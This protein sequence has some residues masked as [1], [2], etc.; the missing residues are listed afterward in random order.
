MPIK[1]INTPDFVSGLLFLA[2]G[3]SGIALGS[4]YAVGN[5]MR[6]GPGY[7]PLILGGALTL[8]GLV[9][10]VRCL[11]LGVTEEDNLLASFRWR[12]ALFVVLSVVVF[13]LLAQELGLLL[14]TVVMTLVSGLARTEIHF[15]EL[16]GLSVGLAAFGVAVFSF[17]LGLT[18]PI[19]P[20]V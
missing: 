3:I 5:A 9:V 6:M 2:A 18:L 15:P 7:F 13:G 12:P 4:S 1:V 14:A 11:K 17:G 10:L 16:L 20:V 8:L 19:L